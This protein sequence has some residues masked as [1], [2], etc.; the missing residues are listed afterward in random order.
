[1]LEKDVKHLSDDVSEMQHI[2]KSLVKTQHEMNAS[3]HTIKYIVG[4]GLAFSAAL[5]KFL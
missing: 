4:L 5:A 3:L 1:M 2:V